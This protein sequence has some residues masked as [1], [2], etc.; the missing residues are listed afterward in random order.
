MK[1][2]GTVRPGSSLLRSAWACSRQQPASRCSCVTINGADGPDKL[3]FYGAHGGLLPAPAEEVF[4]S[5]Y[6][7]WA[8]DVARQFPHIILE[9]EDA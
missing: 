2:G 8:N 4:P 1:P 9:V 5:P 3:F 7:A 6:E